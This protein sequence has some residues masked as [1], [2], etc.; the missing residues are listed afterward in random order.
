MNAL[1]TTR[2][3]AW[4]N[5]ALLQEEKTTLAVKKLLDIIIHEI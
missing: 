3:Q 2:E 1:Q 4:E 5:R